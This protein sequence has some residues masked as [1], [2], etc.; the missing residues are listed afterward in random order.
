MGIDDPYSDLD[1][2][3]L[4][5]ASRL[6]EYDT[7]SFTRFIEFECHGKPGHMN[8]QDIESFTTAC[9]ACDM[10][11]LYQLRH[12]EIITD[13]VGAGTLLIKTAAKPMRE[14]VR[15]AFF[16]FHYV[17]MRGEHRACDNPM[18][19]NEPVGTLLSLSK[20]LAHA[21]RAA[22][23]LDGEPYPY[24][25]WLFAAAIR[26]PTGKQLQP[27]YENILEYLSDDCLRYTGQEDTNPVGLELRKIRMILI[28]AARAHGID[29]PWLTQWWLY[30]DQA[31]D[32]VSD[33]QW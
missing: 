33:I 29:E 27:S 32:A 16:F 21:L 4:I 22:I 12:A 23:V 6:T 3:G 2:W 14:S 18:N 17:E 11:I 9:T 5:P 8:I 28:D 25:K 24:D 15:N 26:N 1:L 7:N 20:T 19:R 13:P 10:D 31:R 30:I